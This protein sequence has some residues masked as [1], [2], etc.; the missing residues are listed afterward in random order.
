MRS[1][2][3]TLFIYY[4]K[5]LYNKNFDFLYKSRIINKNVAILQNLIKKLKVKLI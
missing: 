4:S 5:I 2:F 1:I 3:N